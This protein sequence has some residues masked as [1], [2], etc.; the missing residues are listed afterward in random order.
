M[1]SREKC[2]FLS[3]KI[4][5]LG[6]RTLGLVWLF[7]GDQIDCLSFRHYF[8]ILG[9]RKEGGLMKDLSYALKRLSGSLL[10]HFCLHVI[11]Q[12]LVM[13]IQV[14]AKESWN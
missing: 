4:R 3:G 11:G 14:A 10:E 13:W 2:P 7:Q 12:N 1:P 6:V 5:R 9:S 8:C